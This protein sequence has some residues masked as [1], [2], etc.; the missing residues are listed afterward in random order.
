MLNALIFLHCP[1]R[2]LSKEDV[3]TI[4]LSVTMVIVSELVAGL[5][6]QTTDYSIASVYY[7]IL[8]LELN[9][10]LILYFVYL[11]RSFF[12]FKLTPI[13]SFLC[14]ICDCCACRVLCAHVGQ[15]H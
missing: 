2:G 15:N 4:V 11:N 13:S 5:E 8:Y 7:L 3:N 6:Q 9:L 1:H 12:V 14:F 10:L